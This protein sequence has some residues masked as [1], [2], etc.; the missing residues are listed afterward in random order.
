MLA[1]VRDGVG[2]NGQGARGNVPPGEANKSP[3]GSPPIVK[4]PP[5]CTPRNPL[6]KSPC[7]VVVKVRKSLLFLIS[8]ETSESLVQ[9]LDAATEMSR[10]RQRGL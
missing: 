7:M 1:W 4:C 2:V 6:P 8:D 10:R 5:V 9:P 3:P